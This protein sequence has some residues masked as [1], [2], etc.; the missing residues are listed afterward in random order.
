MDLNVVTLN[1]PYPPDY[2]GMIDSFYRIKWIKAE[3]VSIHLHCFEYD[4]SRSEEIESHCTTVNYYQRK[5]SLWNHLSK[6]PYIVKSRNSI[7][8]LKNLQNNDFPILFD[9]LHTTYFLNHP[10]LDGR[11]KFIR[12][13]NIEHLYYKSLAYFE[14]NCLKKIYF[15]LESRKLRN[16]EERISS[17]VNLLTISSQDSNYFACNNKK[18]VFLPPFHP[19]EEVISNKGKGEY[20]L[21]HGDLSVRENSLV[22]CS[23]I[24]NVFSRLNY[25]CIIAGKKPQRTLLRKA[26][27]VKKLRIIADPDQGEM[28]YLI[29]NAHINILPA[30]TSNGFKLKHLIALFA[31]RFCISNSTAALNFEDKSLFHIANS[32]EEMIKII[33]Q[34]IMIEFSDESI[35]KRK[36]SLEK[37]FSNKMNAKKFTEIIF[38]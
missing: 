15:S 30:L 29:R 24:K 38:E 18:V 14:I 32:D 5:T 8:L 10:Y 21:F 28:E 20:I 26:H 23:L 11:K 9:G 2:G 6:I 31:G 13:H 37:T 33:N 25:N 17:S 35:S 27:G 4:R 16:Y 3:G 22:A 1:I 36:K 12:T 7:D 34:L 19:F